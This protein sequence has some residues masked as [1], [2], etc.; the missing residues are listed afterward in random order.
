MAQNCCDLT[1]IDIEEQACFGIKTT[2]LV[3]EYSTRQDYM[4]N[5]TTEFHDEFSNALHNA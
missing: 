2:L 4:Q 5:K 3:I 1:L